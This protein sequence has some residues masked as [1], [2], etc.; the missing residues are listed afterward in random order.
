VTDMRFPTSCQD[1][2]ARYKSR[3]PIVS[4]RCS[5]W[6]MLQKGCCTYGLS[7]VTKTFTPS[8]KL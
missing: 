2:L 1:Q 7:G 3:A 6:E 8:K 5:G 4:L